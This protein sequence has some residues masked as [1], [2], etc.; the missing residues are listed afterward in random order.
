MGE[1][2]SLAEAR[3]ARQRVRA[4][5]QACDAPFRDAPHAR[6]A[7][8]D[9]ARP[10]HRGDRSF[11]AWCACLFVSMV[12]TIECGGPDQR[13]VTAPPAPTSLG[14]SRFREQ[15]W[16]RMGEDGWQYLRRSSSKDDSIENDD[17]APASP[18]HVLRIVFTPDMKPNTGPSVHWTALDHVKEVYTGWWMKLSPNWSCSPAGCGKITFLFTD[19]AGQ[20]YTNVYHSAESDG[21]PYRIGVNT[22][23]APYGQQI[24]YP[25]VTTTP[26]SP[27]EWHRI[28]FYYRWE[29][30]PGASNDGIIRW[31]VD[32]KVNGEYQNVHY[33]GSSFIEL[34]Y[35]PTLQN[36]PPAE[37]YM[38]VDH[39][40]VG[41]R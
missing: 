20:V 37:Q 14:W 19:G 10:A 7:P 36:P 35:A 18:P 27:G 11:G 29:T 6:S 25:N 23:W 34:Q 33:P 15:P 28:E 9:L 5:R 1:L 12:I 4:F 3:H 38:Y 39:T 17:T 13:S 40:S 41:V 16:T 22:E 21:P 30:T 31:W 32:G 26:V 8:V 2:K 24:W